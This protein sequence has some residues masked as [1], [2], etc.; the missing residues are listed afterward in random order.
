MS[1]PSR[2]PTP[3]GFTLIEL[4][5]VVSIIGVLAAI[6]IPGFERLATKAKAA[7][8]AEILHRLKRAVDD[9]YV[10]NGAVLGGHL[11]AEFQPA[12]A[13]ATNVRRQPDWKAAG[14]ADLLKTGE[15][16]MGTL[17][18]S[19]QVEAW[20]PDAGT[21]AA[22]EVTIYGDADGDGV[23]SAVLVRY[24]RTDG[25]YRQVSPSAEAL[26]IALTSYPF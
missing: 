3:R 6:A 25:V 24:E 9:M 23:P 20:D 12:A 11:L 2:R 8:R 5:M 4:M 18:Y 19:Y 17:Y 7:E 21:P 26:A 10:Q 13:G 1:R 22:L 16:I 15:E 14:W